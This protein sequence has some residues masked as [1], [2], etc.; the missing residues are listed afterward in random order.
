M[1]I[2]GTACGRGH[3][4]RTFEFGKHDMFM[5]SHPDRNC[6]KSVLSKNDTHPD[7]KGVAAA[8]FKTTFLTYF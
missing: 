6:G 8:S 1:I 3:R 2:C 7:T 5:N 4:N